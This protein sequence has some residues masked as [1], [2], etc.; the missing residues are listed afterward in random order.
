M[1]TKHID[2]LASWLKNNLNIETVADFP[3]IFDDYCQTQLN[4]K[5][6]NTIKG[7]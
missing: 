1:D 5:L 4:T 7:Q 6:E 3:Q 2:Q